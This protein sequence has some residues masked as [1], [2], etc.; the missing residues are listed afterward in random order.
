MILILMG[1]LDISSLNIQVQA[2]HGSTEVQTDGT[3]LYTPDENYF[4]TDNFSY[5][6]KDNN[7]AVSS[8]TVVTITIASI[9]DAPQA[10]K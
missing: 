1:Q 10:Q 8:A 9:N 2:Q 3:I 6:V 5:T 4:G 7:D